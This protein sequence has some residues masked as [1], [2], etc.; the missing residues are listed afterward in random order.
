MDTAATRLLLT[1]REAEEVAHRGALA[2]LLS[3]YDDVCD[4][5]LTEEEQR[6]PLR[7]N[8]AIPSTG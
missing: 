4:E 7:P 3:A 5:L 2:R 8:T 1:V 6:G